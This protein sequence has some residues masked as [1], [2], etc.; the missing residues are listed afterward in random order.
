MTC[1]SDAPSPHAVEVFRALTVLLNHD[2]PLRNQ[3]AIALLD[4][5]RLTEIN[6][7]YGRAAGA[8]TLGRVSTALKQALQPGE[9]AAYWAGDQYVLLL[10]GAGRRAALW[11]TRRILSHVARPAE[12]G[13]PAVS[14]SA[15]IASYPAD[16]LTNLSLVE[17]AAVELRRAKR[18]G[19]GRVRASIWLAP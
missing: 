5:D 11:R 3:H 8:A 19:R 9:Q 1:S 12:Q 15:G 13:W 2:G 6:L 16:G 18:H 7:A 10:P 4:M 14:L 17:A